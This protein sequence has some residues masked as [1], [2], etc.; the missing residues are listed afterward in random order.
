MGAA[1]QPGFQVNEPRFH[2]TPPPDKLAQVLEP[3]GHVIRKMPRSVIVG[4]LVGALV[5]G[6]AFAAWLVRG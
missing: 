5:I 3:G 4:V 6:A 2:P 1:T